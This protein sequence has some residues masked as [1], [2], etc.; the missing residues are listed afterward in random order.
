M[1]KNKIFI[2]MRFLLLTESV[3][4]TMDLIF[5][6]VLQLHILMYCT[7]KNGFKSL[8]NLE[9]YSFSE[10]FNYCFPNSF[11]RN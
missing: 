7:F 4:R 6:S 9:K 10:V 2:F 1:N 8:A 3:L 11:K 5:G